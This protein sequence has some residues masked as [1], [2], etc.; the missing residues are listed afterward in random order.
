MTHD[1]IDKL[2][3]ESAVETDM[4]LS[5]DFVD[6]LSGKIS[7]A[8]RDAKEEVAKDILESLLRIETSGKPNI[9]IM[10]ILNFAYAM[11]KKYVSSTR[12]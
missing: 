3:Y 4:T 1:D 7:H 10:D 12:P 9:T 2:I 6:T 5:G 8:I 11:A